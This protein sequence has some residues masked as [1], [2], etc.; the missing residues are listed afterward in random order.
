M[1]SP[2]L[3]NLGSPPEPAGPLIDELVYERRWKILAILC[4]SLVTIVIAVSS[5]NVAI[6]TIIGAL[7]AKSTESLWII[8]SYALTFAIFLL[9]AGALGDRYGRK[10]ALLGGLGLFGSMAFLA[11]FATGPSHLIAARALMG[12]GAAFIMPATLSIITHTFPPEERNKAIAMWAGFAG[13]GGALGPLMSGLALKW[14]SWSAVFLVNLPLVILLIV[15]VVA[16]VPNS[17][18]PHGHALDPIGALISVFML[19]GLVLGII[20]G[21]EWGWTSPG[22]LGAL[23]CALVGAVA[24]IG[25]ERS[26]A[27]PMLDPRLFKRRGFSM[28]SLGLVLAFFSM[29]GVFYVASQYLQFVHGYTALETGVRTLPSAAMMILISP[30][31]PQIS[32]QL[33]VKRAVRLGFLLIAVGLF[34]MAQLTETS[35]YPPFAVSLM[36]MASGM[37]VLM[38]PCSAMIVS[39]V[40]LS[41]AGVGSA[42]NDVTREVGG[43][44]GIAVTGSVLSAG[45]SSSMATKTAKVPLP[46][47]IRE[48]VEDSIG[49]AYIVAERAASQVGA[50][51]AM[52]LRK[53]A[54]ES[55]ISGSH[56]ALL[57]AS[58][59]ALVG[60]LT[61][62]TWIPNV[63]PIP[64]SEP[65][66]L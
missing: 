27:Q 4:L 19:G 23:L 2:Q 60:S 59:V 26:V 10:W 16:F 21:P 9:P 1:T 7:N 44:I 29:F 33:G 45:Y 62:G 64:G 54:A 65:E 28:G 42:V 50:E 35:S 25:Y 36:L 6:P 55:F 14:F 8:E 49:K 31:S 63:A 17:R 18:D 47:A 48:A 39:S 3:A 52:A 24:F 22:V 40:P 53:A 66:A 58:A 32:A 46:P 38:A 37:G 30:R 43:A 41:K 13:A 51:S 56:N 20:E 15:L 5:L 34:G 57:L 11:S 61:V 12:V